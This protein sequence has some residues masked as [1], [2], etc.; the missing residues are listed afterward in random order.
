MPQMAGSDVR[1][2]R[3]SLGVTV[4]TF[5]MVLGVHPSTIHRW[6]SAGVELVA[7]EGV[8]W[9]VLWALRKRVIRARLDPE[10]VRNGGQEVSDALVVGG[11][12][13]ALAALIA[14]ACGQK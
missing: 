4:Q 11:A 14:F 3:T 12:L 8:P 5:A 10:V 6:E 7:I 2:I 13:L 9:K 1:V